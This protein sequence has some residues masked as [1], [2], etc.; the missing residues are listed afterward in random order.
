LTPL[1]ERT[2][3]ETQERVKDREERAGILRRIEDRTA[4]TITH[5]ASGDL[6]AGAES[7]LHN[8]VL[9]MHR[10]GDVNIDVILLNEGLLA[11]RLRQAGVPVTVFPESQL[12]ALPLFARIR[13]HLAARR[14]HIVHTHRYK[15][16]VL[17]ALAAALVPGT[18]STRTL[19]GAP[20]FS[21]RIWEPRQKVPQ[22]LDWLVARF[23]QFPIVCVSSELRDRCAQSLPSRRLRV[24]PNGVDF[25]ALRRVA[26]QPTDALSGRREFR[27]GFFG[28]LTSVKRVDVILEV[29][30]LLEQR[31]QGQFAL[32]IFGEGP[33]RSAL[34]EQARR[35]KLDGSV[36]FMGFVAEPAAW[37]AKMNAL[38]I[39]SDH[40]GLPMIVLEAMGLGV[41]VISH[42]VGAIPEVLGGG[43]LGTLIPNQDPSRYADAVIALRDSPELTR[44]KTAR[45]CQHVASLYSA[46]HTVQQYISIYRELRNNRHA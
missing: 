9:A 32:Y 36:H 45:A 40:E 11:D 10:T 29:A 27:I 43:A 39:T 17:G 16:N 7:Q 26:A 2:G 28:R 8:M 15:E 21:A 25:D 34:E 20:E 38:L 41:P 44:A 33:L 18:R 4:M 19:H 31:T 24:V 46:E 12:G 30:A 5:L 37:L 3:A 14:T 13:R 23:I 6:W 22:L 42:A 35:L 1:D